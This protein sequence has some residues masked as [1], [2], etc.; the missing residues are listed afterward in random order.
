MVKYAVYFK[1]EQIVY[2]LWQIEVLTVNGMTL[3]E[4]CKSLFI[5]NK[6][7]LGRVFL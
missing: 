2:F 4:A 1:P 5:D 6:V 7:L 3:N